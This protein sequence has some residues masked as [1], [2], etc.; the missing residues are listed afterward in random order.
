MCIRELAIICKHLRRM[1]SCLL[2]YVRV[3]GRG[4]DSL[5]YWMFLDTRIKC[6]DI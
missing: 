4:L 6:Y 3:S 1:L 2:L 5:D